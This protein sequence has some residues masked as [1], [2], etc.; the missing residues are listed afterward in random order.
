MYT[1][2]GDDKCG[3]MRLMRITQR[4][5]GIFQEEGEGGV[6]FKM[7]CENSGSC[8]KHL[9]EGGAGMGAMELIG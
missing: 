5:L 4:R 8:L 3:C 1:H 6:D 9:L 2:R 7:K